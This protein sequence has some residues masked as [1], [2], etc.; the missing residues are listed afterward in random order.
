MIS[1]P[2]RNFQERVISGAK[3]TEIMTID[4][5]PSETGTF[6]YIVVGAGSAGCVVA[7]RLSENPRYTVLL[8][9]A[10]GVDKDW[11]IEMPLGVGALLES[12]AHNWNYL[13]EPEPHLNNRQISHPRGR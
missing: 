5:S 4:A 3:G 11:R 10:G 1:R 9:E 12:G 8:L 6:D 2:T 7:A 13:T